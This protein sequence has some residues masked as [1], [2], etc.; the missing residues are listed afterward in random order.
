MSSLKTLGSIKSK[1]GH[2]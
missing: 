2:R 1:L